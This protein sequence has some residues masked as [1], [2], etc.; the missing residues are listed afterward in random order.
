MSRAH[1]SSASGVLI[2]L[3]IEFGIAKTVE[4]VPDGSNI[5]VRRE[6]RIQ[7]IQLVSHYRLSKQIKLQSKAFFE[8]LSE[9]IDAKWLRCAV[10]LS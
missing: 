5:P 2:S 1:K 9:M 4:L 7:Y 3:K 6:N 8:G 10:F